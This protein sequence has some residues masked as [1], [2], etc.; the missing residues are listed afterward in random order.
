VTAAFGGNNM[1]TSYMRNDVQLDELLIDGVYNTSNVPTG[2]YADPYTYRSQKVINSLYGF[3]SFG[4]DDTYYLDITGRNDWSSAL[5]AANR[6]YYYPSVSGSVLLDRLFDFKNNAPFVTFSKLRLSWANVGNDTN[7][8]SLDQYY[9]ASSISGGYTLPGTIPDPNIK[10]ENVES[11]ELGLES[12]FLQN[13]LGFDACVYST[14]ATN[15]IV[16]IDQDPI[17]GASSM[18]VNAGEIS[19][20]GIE[21][22]FSATPVKT[23]DFTWTVNANWSKNKTVLVSLYDSYNPTVPF[24][25]DMGTTIGGRVHCYTY[26]GHEMNQLYGIGLKRAAEGSYYLDDNGKKIDCSGQVLIDASTGLPSLTT[27]SDT[28]LGKIDPD[29]KGGFNTALRYKNLT[30]NMSFTFQKGGHRYSV[31][32]GI[33][34]YQGKLTNTLKG[35]YDGIVAEGVNIVSTNEDGSIVCQKNNTITSNIYTYYQAYAQNTL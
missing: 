1:S 7:P 27:T 32:D 29:W 2:I 20:K 28:Y 12:K 3:A 8:Y 6:S 26:V 13:R 16:S 33:L 24:E 30:L 15:Q 4:W 19:N 10:P 11:W 9:S 14:S 18:K 34:S 21:L 5:S 25:T 31:T 35:R 23:K 22:S 17:V